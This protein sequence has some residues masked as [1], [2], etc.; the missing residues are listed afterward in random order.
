[1]STTERDEHPIKGGSTNENGTVESG[2]TASTQRCPTTNTP[3]PTA[4]HVPAYEL[5]I[6]ETLCRMALL[7]NRSLTVS[8]AY[9]RDPP[10]LGP[11]D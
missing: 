11:I 1:M 3:D 2:P 10:E 9:V 5:G 6:V 4:P 7:R 8:G